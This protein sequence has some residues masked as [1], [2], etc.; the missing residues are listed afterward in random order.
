MR[1]ALAGLILSLGACAPA[2]V[3]VR[4]ETPVVVQPTYVE[5]NVRLPGA[6]VPAVEVFYEEL[7]PHGTWINDPSYGWIFVPSQVDYVPYR[8]GYWVDAEYGMTWVSNEPFGWAVCH[9]GRWIHTDRWAWVPDTTWGPAW[10]DWREGDGLVGWHASGP[11]GH[12]SSNVSWLFVN[13]EVTLRVDVALHY[14]PNDRDQCLSRTHR[15]DRHGRTREGS[16]WTMG[17]DMASSR[18]GGHHAPRDAR[19]IGRYEEADRREA[20]QRA[21]AYRERRRQ[22]ATRQAE[23]ARKQRELADRRAAEEQRGRDAADARRKAEERQQRE[24]ADRRAAEEQRGR[25]AE[26]ARRAEQDRKQR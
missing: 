14:V 18:A 4:E 2:L 8:D 7:A 17:P 5:L 19:S 3:V 20:E 13:V 12:P 15:V 16:V 26:A 11:V 1:L 21:N 10:V 25:D 23:E 6:A 9:Y 22:E 24:I